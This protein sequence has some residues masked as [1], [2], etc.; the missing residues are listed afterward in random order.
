[1]LA[2]AER[3]AA[4][5]AAERPPD[6]AR[7]AP[8]SCGVGA[9]AAAGAGAPHSG[10]TVRPDIE[11]VSNVLT[12]LFLAS[13]GLIMRRGGARCG[14]ACASGS[15]AATGPADPSRVSPHGAAP[16]QTTPPPAFLLSRPTPQPRV[17]LEPRAGPHRWHLPP[18]RRQ[19]RRRRCR[20]PGARRA[21]PHVVG[22]RARD[23]AHWGVCIC[24]AEH[25]A[26]AAAA[27]RDGA[28]AGRT[29]WL[30]AGRA[31]SGMARAARALSPASRAFLPAPAAGR[32]DPAP[33][34]PLAPALARPTCCCW[35]SP[36]C[37][38]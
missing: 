34:T 23:R 20:L 16:A 13:I 9:G 26:P 5:P 17:P 7:D 33:P 32:P 19:G 15:M 36:R 24:P 38:S 4:M 18:R 12:A 21:A 2:A 30:P 3:A 25:G 28:R 1:M 8:E 11:S 10:R 35:A 37:H 29:G 31:R 22:R 6:A 27:A 14:G